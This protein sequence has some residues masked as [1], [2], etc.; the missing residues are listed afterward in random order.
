M[1][2]TKAVYSFM[3]NTHIEASNMTNIFSKFRRCSYS[4][5]HI[6]RIM[7]SSL[8][9]GYTHLVGHEPTTLP[10]TL[11]QREEVTI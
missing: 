3:I 9:I 4:L 6:N 7:T 8:A 11:L 5:I 2:E 10:S 1:G